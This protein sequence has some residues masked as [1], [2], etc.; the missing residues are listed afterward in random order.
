LAVEYFFDISKNSSTQYISGELNF[1]YADIN[2]KDE[3]LSQLKDVLLSDYQIE[4]N[5]DDNGYLNISESEYPH[6]QKVV[7]DNFDFILELKQENSISLKVQVETNEITPLIINQVKGKLQELGLDINR[8]KL[9]IS[10]DKKQINIEVSSNLK[11]NIFDDLGLSFNNKVNRFGIKRIYTLKEI[12]GLE[13]VG[14]EYHITFIPNKNK[15]IKILKNIHDKNDDP[16]F[17]QLPT[18]YIFALSQN[19]D[20][21]KLWDFKTKTDIP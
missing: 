8:I 11:T 6:I 10:E 2:S 18:R 17:R 4:T 9:S 1:K 19:I 15:S 16:S 3:I 21:E 5:I 14:N 7:N 12:D 13:I 20:K